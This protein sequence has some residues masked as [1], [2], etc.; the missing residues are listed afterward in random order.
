MITQTL[1]SLALAVMIGLGGAQNAFAFGGSV[2][3]GGQSVVCFKSGSDVAASETYDLFEGQKLFGYNY[4]PSGQVTALEL[5]LNI[6]QQIDLILP[7]AQPELTFAERVTQIAVE[8]E[9]ATDRKDMEPTEDILATYL[10]SSCSLLQVVVFNADQTISVNLSGFQQLST[11]SQT[12]LYLHEAIFWYLREVAG[13]TSSRRTRRIVSYLMS[14][15]VA[16]V[17]VNAMRGYDPTP[18]R[19][20]VAKSV[21]HAASHLQNLDFYLMTD[22]SGGSEL[23]VSDFTSEKLLQH[24]ALSGGPAGLSLVKNGRFQSSSA[25]TLQSPVSKARAA[26]S[27]SFHLSSTSGRL[28]V[29]RRGQ[30]LTYSLQC[31]PDNDPLPLSL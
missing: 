8:L 13:D 22:P 2:G 15:G 26:Q 12:A 1:S 29:T 20:R 14:G 24:L 9:A 23:L 28:D 30:K 21:G 19:C 16:K 4:R 7:I 31:R 11:A 10:P 18:I 27:Y 17:A 5:A 6:A 25:V 3:N